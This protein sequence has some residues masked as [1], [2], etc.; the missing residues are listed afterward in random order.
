MRPP[1]FNILLTISNCSTMWFVVLTITIEIICE[2]HSY[3]EILFKKY[4]TE[5]FKVRLITNL[6]FI[7]VWQTKTAKSWMSLDDAAQFLKILV[8]SLKAL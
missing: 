3:Y 2:Y 7:Q 8:R 5:H 1:P 6:K 4:N